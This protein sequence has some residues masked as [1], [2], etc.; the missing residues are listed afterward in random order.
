M[1]AASSPSSSPTTSRAA[2]STGP[3]PVSPATTASSS[4]GGILHAQPPPWAYWVSRT[5][6]GAVVTQTNLGAPARQHDQ[7]RSLFGRLPAQRPAGRV[8]R[9]LVRRRAVE[10]HGVPSRSGLIGQL[11]ARDP[12]QAE[13]PDRLALPAPGHQ[14]VAV[15]G[16][17]EELRLHL[18]PAGRALAVP[19]VE[20]DD[21]VLRQALLEVG[22]HDGGALG[23]DADQ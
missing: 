18:A 15:G 21:P 12:V 7:A 5:V 20:D 11:G 6:A 8:G 19:V 16:P 2:G 4:P 1:T 22:P 3:A 14:I 23:F 13:P 17:G 10:G 9:V